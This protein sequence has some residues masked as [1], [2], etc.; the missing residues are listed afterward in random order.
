MDANA[1][2]DDAVE[3]YLRESDMPR[4]EALA[5]LLSADV[6]EADA[7]QGGAVGYFVG[8]SHYCTR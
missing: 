1:F 3:A 4:S 6:C 5:F 8:G 7:C 2:V